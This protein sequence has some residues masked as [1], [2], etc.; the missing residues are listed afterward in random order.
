VTEFVHAFAG[1]KDSVSRVYRHLQILQMYKIKEEL[2]HNIRKILKKYS[3]CS[4]LFFFTGV[5]RN[6]TLKFIGFSEIAAIIDSSPSKISAG[7][8]Q[9]ISKIIASHNKR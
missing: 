4:C 6:D 8:V 1:T 7:P 2:I 5:T 3:V 9:L